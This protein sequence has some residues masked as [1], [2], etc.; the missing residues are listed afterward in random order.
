MSFTGPDSS[1]FPEDEEALGVVLPGGELFDT[2][3]T[4]YLHISSLFKSSLHV[5]H[6]VLF[7]RLALTVVPD[8]ID[9]SGVWHNVIKGGIQLCLYDE[10]YA[11][12]MTTPYDK[13]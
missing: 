12:L 2:E 7:S 11:A 9:C 3:F 5:H 8:D 10:A 13:L 6:E 4:F 1:L